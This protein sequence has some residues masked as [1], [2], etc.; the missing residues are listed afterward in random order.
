MARITNLA[1][2]ADSTNKT[3]DTATTLPNVD[4]DL[5]LI[6]ATHLRDN[7]VFSAPGWT[8]GPSNTSGSLTSG[9]LWKRSSGGETFPLVTSS[10]PAQN[11]QLLSLIVK[12]ADTTT[13]FIGTAG[14]AGGSGNSAVSGT[15]SPGAANSLI[16]ESFATNADHAPM[17]FDSSVPQIFHG[18]NDFQLSLTLA[19]HIYQP[20]TGSTTGHTA[21]SGFAITPYVGLTVAIA[22]D[23][24][25][26]IE[27]QVR[28]DVAPS[29]LIHPLVAAGGRY[30]A[31]DLLH[32]S[33]TD[34]DPTT[35]AGGVT[36]LAGET[37]EFLSISE[38]FQPFIPGSE[39]QNLRPLW[40]RNSHGTTADYGQCEIH[41]QRW[42]GT[43]DLTDKVMSVSLNA[44]AQNNLATVAEGGYVFGLR[45]GA[46]NDGAR[47]WVVSGKDAVVSPLGV[48]LPVQVQTGRPGTD[49]GTFNVA[50]VT[51]WILGG[52]SNDAADTIGY[53]YLH[54]LDVMHLCGGSAANP[55]NFTAAAK[56][57]KFGASLQTVQS[58]SSQ[59]Q[60]TFYVAHRLKF[61]GVPDFPSYIDFANQ[62]AEWPAPYDAL[63]NRVQCNVDIGAF[64]LEIEA[65]STDEFVGV[66]NTNLNFVQHP[67]VITPGSDTTVPSDWN[68]GTIRAASLVSLDNI[69]TTQFAGLRFLES[70]EVLTQ[71]GT[72]M[73]GGLTIESTTGT[74]GITR[75]SQAELDFIANCTFRNNSRAM[76]ISGDQ[77]GDLNF[78][79][80]VTFSG[81]TVD[82]AYN[83]ATDFNLNVPPSTTG[84]VNIANLGAGTMTVVPSSTFTITNIQVGDEILMVQ[85]TPTVEVRIITTATATSLISSV[86]M[87]E[88]DAWFCRITRPGA[89]NSRFETF[90]TIVNNSATVFAQIEADP[91]RVLDD[92]A[93]LALT[94]LAIDG[95]LGTYR[96]TADNS[97]QNVYD[98]QSA[99]ANQQANL[100]FRPVMTGRNPTLREINEINDGEGFWACIADGASVV[101]ETVQ[102][103][104]SAGGSIAVVNGGLF[105]DST[106]VR[107]HDAAGEHLGRRINRNVQD[108]ATN[109]PQ[110]GA[111]VAVWDTSGD[112]EQIYSLTRTRGA[113]TT[114]ASGNCVGYVVYQIG[115]TVHT[116]SQRISKYGFLVSSI[117]IAN[118]G[119]AIG[120]AAAP[121]TNRLNTDA[122]RT[123]SE[124]AAL[125]ITGV[126]VTPGTRIVDA[127][128]NN[129]S[130]AQDNLK[131]RL[132]RVADISTGVPGYSLLYQEGDWIY[133]D[134]GS[135]FIQLG[136]WTTQNLVDPTDQIEGGVIELGTPGAV[137]LNL[138]DITVRYTTA[139]T[140]PTY[141]HRGQ[142][143][144]GTITL[145][146]SSALVVSCEFDPAVTITN[147]EPGNITVDQTV[148]VVPVITLSFDP[149]F[150][151]DPLAIAVAIHAST[152]E[153]ATP[154]RVRDQS[155]NEVFVTPADL[156]AGEYTFNYDINN[157][158]D[159]GHVP[160]TPL[161][162]VLVAM[163]DGGCRYGRTDFTIQPVASATFSVD[164]PVETNP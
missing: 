7:A 112:T 13:P 89:R 83:G 123:L 61:G 109:N 103:D 59:G 156:T 52:R 125:A 55:L 141:N 143:I 11:F 161:D 100:G 121:E 14:T 84:L 160:G 146:T 39:T 93:A 147:N 144:D 18:D 153:T 87:G 64:G 56:H 45:T 70:A 21:H 62:S 154:V 20:S 127:G 19:E 66:R 37:A 119:V 164:C 50:S 115:A 133:S 94:G 139:S 85:V 114:D 150:I 159:G 17:L 163:G 33:E 3:S 134:N 6:H 80:D 73:S 132:A 98:Y 67:F 151:A 140:A 60:T 86:A 27:G 48:I 129:L 95:S 68:G 35:G 28:P 8:A 152:F 79:G 82:V 126:T 124:A 75:T 43:K 69:G 138:K 71:T 117:P 16:L 130:D 142:N 99:W 102:I 47:M 118:Q 96:W 25:G 128:N 36:T 106:G 158:T 116:L 90:G 78:P 145:T 92:A 136:T 10:R 104:F 88:G 29:E 22:D 53:G 105:E 57:A 107:W 135:A 44:G 49:Y 97:E 4:G 113:L 131:A 15:M 81:N 30:E 110:P 149:D 157:D 72:D 91:F 162:V 63:T 58:Q 148:T 120:T 76:L 2:K 26:N 101:S 23:G 40:A 54:A 65:I 38:A 74:Q 12:D 41:Q 1:Y 77:A 24:N 155:L 31:R 5:M 34:T 46:T 108:T 9:W 42:S 51:G 122:R 137:A 111:T 32:A